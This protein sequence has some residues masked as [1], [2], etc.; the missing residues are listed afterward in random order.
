MAEERVTETNGGGEEN[1]LVV[2]VV[3]QVRKGGGRGWWRCSV[4]CFC[5]PFGLLFSFVFFL[6]VCS[7][8]DRVKLFPTSAGVGDAHGRSPVRE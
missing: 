8:I 3:V 5:L 7:E 2:V 1:L 4:H 6:G